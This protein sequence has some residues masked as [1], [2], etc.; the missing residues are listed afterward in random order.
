MR[1]TGTKLGCGEGGCGA[2]T[3]MVSRYERTS[4][5][6]LLEFLAMW[7][8]YSS[9]ILTFFYKIQS[10]RRQRLPDPDM[11]C[12][13]SSRHH[14]GRYR[15]ARWSRRSTTTTQEAPACRSRTTSQSPWVSMWILYPR[16]RHVHVH[17][18]KEQQE[19]V[20]HYGRSGGRFSR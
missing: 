19:R 15:S 13:R 12:A 2:C 10:L 1:L 20:A 7:K 3:V 6:I 18:A 9:L 8:I 16:L 17:V 14:G 5:T 4:K 11:R